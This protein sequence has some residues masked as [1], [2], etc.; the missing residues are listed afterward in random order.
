MTS[1]R[2]SNGLLKL[3]KSTVAIRTALRKGQCLQTS[4]EHR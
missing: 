1:A 3:S 4:F 2:R